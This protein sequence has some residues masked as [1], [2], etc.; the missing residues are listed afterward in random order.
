MSSKMEINRA[1]IRSRQAGTQ[2]GGKRERERERKGEK[3]F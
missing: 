2:Q 1:V 3:T